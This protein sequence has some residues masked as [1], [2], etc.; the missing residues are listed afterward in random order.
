M[1][2]IEIRKMFK[3]ISGQKMSTPQISV[4]QN[5]VVQNDAAQNGVD[6]KS[7]ERVTRMLN[8][9]SGIRGPLRSDVERNSGIEIFTAR[10]R[11]DLVETHVATVSRKDNENESKA[12]EEVLVIGK[13]CGT[14]IVK[15]T[16]I[17][18]CFS[19]F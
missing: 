18:F 11:S 6:V 10:P 13:Q 4:D 8:R 1:D 12:T 19:K 3:N 9:W 14:T 17:C 2:E 5:D 15:W 16:H 7:V